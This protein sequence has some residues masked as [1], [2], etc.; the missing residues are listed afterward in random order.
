MTLGA[1]DRSS[2]EEACLAPCQYKFPVAR[3]F[4]R[5]LSL[6]VHETRAL[7]EI[8]SHSDRIPRLCR[9]S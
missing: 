1:V 7:Q 6:V 5:S 2:E 4:L 3:L 9:Q 8:M